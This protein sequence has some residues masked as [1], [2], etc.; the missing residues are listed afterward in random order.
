MNVTH[1]WS[2][3]SLVDRLSWFCP[4]KFFF[5]LEERAWGVTYAAIE[6]HW[7]RVTP[8]TCITWFDTHSFIPE[9]PH[10][11][12][13]PPFS[14][15]HPVCGYTSYFCN[16]I[17]SKTERERKKKLF[18][19]SNVLNIQ[20]C[21]SALKE[22][23]LDEKPQCVLNQYQIPL[24]SWCLTCREMQ[25][26]QRWMNFS[27]IFRVKYELCEWFIKN[28]VDKYGCR[29]QHWQFKLS[30][31]S[32]DIKP[33][34]CL[35]CT[36]I[37]QVPVPLSCRWMGDPG[38]GSGALCCA[39]NPQSQLEAHAHHHISLLV[40]KNGK[41]RFPAHKEPGNVQLGRGVKLKPW[42]QVMGSAAKEE[43]VHRG[44]ITET[45]RFDP[46]N[47][48]LFVK[49]TNSREPR[50]HLLRACLF[51]HL[52]SQHWPDHLPARAAPQVTSQAAFPV[53]Q[54]S[55]PTSGP[56]HY[57]YTF[58]PVTVPCWKNSERSRHARGKY[59]LKYLLQ[60]T[61]FSAEQDIIKS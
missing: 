35:Y 56:A 7:L 30:W 2:T 1:S 29:V 13:W 58:T 16:T 51:V 38:S 17:Y 12:H 8:D 36:K 60:G 47:K 40:Q 25:Y 41:E 54:K 22:K 32:C 37:S 4:V 33:I 46:L 43:T 11:K 21:H 59:I 61:G 6:V 3:R 5:L 10:N 53:E 49:F 9:Q 18:F 15:N 23:D 44:G 20:I 55:A 48:H 31:G 28:R 27:N 42:T 34:E 24:R 39:H 50:G 45:Y 26:S 14:R 57:P 52:H 19:S